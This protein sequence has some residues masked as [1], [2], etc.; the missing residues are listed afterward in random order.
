MAFRLPK[1][2]KK[3]LKACEWARKEVIS[4]TTY[5]LQESIICLHSDLVLVDSAGL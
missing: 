3:V 5:L 2:K 4:F 1:N